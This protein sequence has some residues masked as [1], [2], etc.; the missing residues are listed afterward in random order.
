MSDE[1]IMFVQGQRQLQDG[2]IVVKGPTS[3]GSSSSAGFHWTTMKECEVKLVNSCDAST[4][5]TALVTCNN[6]EFLSSEELWGY[7]P[8]ATACPNLRA[9][10]NYSTAMVS[11]SAQVDSLIGLIMLPVQSNA[12][13]VNCEMELILTGLDADFEVLREE[14][15][16]ATQDEM[17]IL[18]Y[19][20]SSS[21]GYVV[22]SF[23]NLSDGLSLVSQAT[24]ITLDGAKPVVGDVYLM[25]AH[26]V[27]GKRQVEFRD[28]AVGTFRLT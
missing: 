19:R 21:K 26:R 17:L 24:L 4:A 6:P 20:A 7:D 25:K 23:R 5:L 1:P 16:N 15:G 10:Q 28:V 18:K 13:V 14:L 3:G 8:F 22:L 9:L 2:R 27:E 11:F 12:W